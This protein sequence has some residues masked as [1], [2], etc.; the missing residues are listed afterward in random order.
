MREDLFL[1]MW[2]WFGVRPVAEETVLDRRRRNHP[3]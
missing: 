2:D 3:G 1:E